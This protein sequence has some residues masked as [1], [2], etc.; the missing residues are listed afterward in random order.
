MS[1]QF[2]NHVRVYP[3]VPNSSPLCQE[4]AETRPSHPGKVPIFGR[5]NDEF[6]VWTHEMTWSDMKWYEMIWNDCR[7]NWILKGWIW[8]DFTWSA[9]LG[10]IHEMPQTN[11][12]IG[13]P[14]ASRLPFLN[15]FGNDMSKAWRAYEGLYP[16][17]M[18]RATGLDW[19]PSRFFSTPASF[20]EKSEPGTARHGPA[21]TSIRPLS[22]WVPH[23]PSGATTT[24]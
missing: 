23:A 3:N 11:A 1:F 15:I 9:A 10:E 17:A 2:L 5:V 8:Q 20:S 22:S 19:I 6:F 4:C 24:P 16:T 21:L 13:S 7:A 14:S 12:V 18:A